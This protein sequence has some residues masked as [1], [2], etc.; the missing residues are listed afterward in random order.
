[1][2]SETKPDDERSGRLRISRETAAGLALVAFGAFA[3]YAAS[4]LPLMRRSGVGS[5]LFPRILA[6][7]I[8]LLG[9]AQTVVGLRT[10]AERV[11]AWHLRRI[12]I[13]VAAVVCFAVT[14]RGIDLGA[15][16]IPPLGLVV[17]TPAAIVIAGLA[18]DDV[19]PRELL[20]FAVVLTAAC[21]ALFRFALGLSLPV[22]PW[23]I[24]I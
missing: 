5:G 19:R 6:G 10:E 15:L 21:V 23:L 13:L 7:L 20:V 18:A 2:T 4:D 8:L 14:I 22:A 16:T 3:M 24:G 12:G 11:G 17:A 1:M 9:V